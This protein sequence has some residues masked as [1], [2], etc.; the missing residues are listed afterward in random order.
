[1]LKFELCYDLGF[2]ELKDIGLILSCRFF[3]QANGTAATLESAR[4]RGAPLLVYTELITFACML[5]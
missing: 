3:A 4:G 1:M 2:S 5:E